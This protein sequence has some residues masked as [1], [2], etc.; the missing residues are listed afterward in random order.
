MAIRPQIKIDL[1]AVLKSG[2]PVIIELGCGRAKAEGRIGIDKLDMPHVDIV[3][4]VE[5]GLSFLPDNSVD[6]I[7]SRSF[8]EHVN[9][10]EGLMRELVRVLKKDGRCHVFVPH[11]SNPY[12]YSDYTHNRF[13]GLYSF[14]YFVDEKYQ[15]KRKVP[16][17]YTDIRIRVL[18]QRLAIANP[19]KKHSWFKKM[20]EV[21]FNHNSSM[22]EFYEENLCYIFPCYG[23]EFVFTPDK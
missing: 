14:Y 23:L 20:I 10:L 22:Q 1:P 5:E 21:I 13:M 2:K 6:E 3:A 11:F 12:F 17:F 16:T 18:S 19:F 4:D 7:H 9:D 8:F 15:L